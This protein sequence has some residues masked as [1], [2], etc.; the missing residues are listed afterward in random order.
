ML[1]ICCYYSIYLTVTGMEDGL[2]TQLIVTI[3]IYI[4]FCDG[5][6]EIPGAHMHASIIVF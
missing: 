6:S 4:L 5:P 3:E 1:D 2:K